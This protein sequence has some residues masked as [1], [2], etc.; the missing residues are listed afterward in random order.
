MATTDKDARR[1]FE[2]LQGI[3]DVEVPVGIATKQRDL[4]RP[5]SAPRIGV[6]CIVSVL[7]IGILEQQCYPTIGSATRGHKRIGGGFKCRVATQ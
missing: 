4:S 5:M 6:F 7:A 1:G 2:C 3:V